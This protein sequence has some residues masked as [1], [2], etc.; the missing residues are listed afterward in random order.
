MRAPLKL[1]KFILLI[2]SVLCYHPP[3]RISHNS[4][5]IDD[6]LLVFGG[7]KNVTHYAC[8]LIYLDLT[9]PFNNGNLSWTLVNDGELPMHSWASASAVSK[10]S[11][12]FLIGGLMRNKSTFN[13]DLSRQVFTFDTKWTA[14]SVTGDIIAPRQQMKGVIDDDSGIIYIFGGISMDSSTFT[15]TL[16]N[17]MSTLDTSSMMWKN[18]DIASNLPLP[19]SDYAAKLLP[20]GNIIYIGGQEDTGEVNYTLVDMKKVSI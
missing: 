7:L 10:Q 9:K 20:D 6:R 15:G 3:L 8:E 11:K 12:I 16:H 14:P 1:F 4:A 2:S 18:L 13:F 17:D 19:C 5:I